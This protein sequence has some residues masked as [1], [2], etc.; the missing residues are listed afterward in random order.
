[1]VEAA[2]CF[3]SEIW[4]LGM[5]GTDITA[6]VRAR[7]YWNS[8]VPEIPAGREALTNEIHALLDNSELS[9][10]QM[11]QL[12]RAYFPHRRPL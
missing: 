8:N 11:A 1:M 9:A 4:A 5:S 6:N 7:L 3:R 10:S 2:N 12:E